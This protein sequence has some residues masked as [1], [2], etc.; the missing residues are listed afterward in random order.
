MYYHNLRYIIFRMSSTN[1]FCGLLARLKIFTETKLV[2]N[3]NTRFRVKVGLITFWAPCEYCVSWCLA[4][5]CHGNDAIILNYLKWLKNKFKILPILVFTKT[6]YSTQTPSG[7]LTLCDL[8][9]GAVFRLTPVSSSDDELEELE[10]EYRRL[11]PIWD[12]TSLEKLSWRK[13]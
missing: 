2:L 5:S 7:H 12:D 11:E 4:L 13:F 9:T 1:Y 10:S 8:V 6:W 3:K